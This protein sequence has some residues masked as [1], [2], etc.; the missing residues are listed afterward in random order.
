[1]IDLFLQHLM[2]RPDISEFQREILKAKCNPAPVSR[3]EIHLNKLNQD[4]HCE[5]EIP[6]LQD[7]ELPDFKREEICKSLEK[8]RN[9]NDV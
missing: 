3:D 8:L 6:E 5:I 1:M 7:T 2:V 9:N 4:I